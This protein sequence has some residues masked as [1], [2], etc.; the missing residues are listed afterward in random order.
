MVFTLDK[1]KQPLGHCTPKRARQ[2]IEKGRACVYRYFPFTIILKDIDIRELV[3]EHCYKIKLDPGSIEF[4]CRSGT[5][6]DYKLYDC[7][8]VLYKG[9]GK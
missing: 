1:R 9:D 2:L 7:H 6:A 3:V 4:S 5:P 8:L